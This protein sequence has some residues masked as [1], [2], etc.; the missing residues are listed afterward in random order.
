MRRMAQ[1]TVD[2]DALRHNLARAREAAGPGRPASAR[3]KRSS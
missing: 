2:T 3:A 1:V